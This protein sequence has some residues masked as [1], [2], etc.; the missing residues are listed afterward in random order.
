M[1]CNSNAKNDQNSEQQH[2][3]EFS[4]DKTIAEKKSNQ[5][6]IKHV[7]TCIHALL[8]HQTELTPDAIALVIGDEQ[9]TYCELNRRANKLARTVEFLAGQ[10]YCSVVDVFERFFLRLRSGS[11][12]LIIDLTTSL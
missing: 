11:L 8:E 1:A 7:N 2:S 10:L 12:K 9:I 5:D 6:S 3:V 4:T